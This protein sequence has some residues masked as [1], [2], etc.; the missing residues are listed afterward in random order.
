MDDTRKAFS[1]LVK[2]PRD[3]LEESGVSGRTILKGFRINKMYSMYCTEVGQTQRSRR[4]FCL[5]GNGLLGIIGSGICLDERLS[6]FYN[7]YAQYVNLHTCRKQRD[8]YFIGE[9]NYMR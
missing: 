3:H 6:T 2:E 4:H 7:G 8:L 1:I 5:H 9:T